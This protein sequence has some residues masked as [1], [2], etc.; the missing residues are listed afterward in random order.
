MKAE[1]DDGTV[2]DTLADLEDAIGT[3]EN[4]MPAI[5]DAVKIGASMGEIM[6]VFEARHGSYSETVGVA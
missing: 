5:I 4:T 1:R 2:E 6:R 3:G